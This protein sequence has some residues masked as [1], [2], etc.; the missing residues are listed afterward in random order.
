[1]PV[2]I[3]ELSFSQI[4]GFPLDVNL[5]SIDIRLS[6]STR[7]PDGLSSIFSQNVGIDDTL[8]YSGSLHFSISTAETYGVHVGLQHP[9]FYNPQGGN[10]LLDVRHFQ[11][12]PGP[13]FTVGGLYGN[14]MTGDSVSSVISIN[15][16]AA[17][18]SPGTEGLLT[19]FTV[20][21]IPE[22]SIS[23]LIFPGL[24]ACIL[25]RRMIPQTQTGPY[26]IRRP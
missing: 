22:P 7:A 9:F 5:A 13:P 21:A 20:T 15:V 26:S 18:G 4:P 11:T 12:L 1:M 24:A 17:T 8:V 3:T 19:R 10:L 2:N 6:T 16:N 25:C 23:L 14:F